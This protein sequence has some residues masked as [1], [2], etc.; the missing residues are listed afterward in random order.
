MNINVFEGARRII[1]LVMVIIALIGIYN[2]VDANPD[3]KLVYEVPFVGIAA[4]KIDGDDCK[5]YEDA[6][7]VTKYVTQAGNEFEL[8]MCFK[9][10]RTDSGEMQIPYKE[11]VDKS[12]MAAG[13]YD[14]NVIQYMR[15]INKGFSISTNDEIFVNKQY[16]PKKLKATL[17]P[18]VI[19]GISIIGF[20]IFC[21][22]VGWV[23]RGFAGIAMGNDTKN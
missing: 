11:N 7:E 13:A 9:A 17:Y 2:A 16:W 23:V 19:A 18:L 4:K 22:V 3:I 21:W 14:E 12:W 20:W 6:K 1:K 10:N 15:L 8:I 5:S